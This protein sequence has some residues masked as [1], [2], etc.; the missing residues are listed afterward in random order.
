MVSIKITGL[1]NATEEVRE[2]T[3]RGVIAG[4]TALGIKGVQLATE[5][6]ASPYNGLPPAVATGNLANSYFSTITPGM[7]LSRL[8]I[9][10]GAPADTYVDPINSGATPHMPP[11]N[12]LLPWVKLK[13]GVDDAKAA[14]G[15]AWAIATNMKEK[16]MLGR[17]MVDRAQ[18]AIEPLGPGAIEHGIAEALRAA[19]LAGGNV[20]AQ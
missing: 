1:E 8:A 17:H 10:A 2:A 12:A 9:Q 11:V 18:A 20:A 5:A 15:I 7:F 19:G 4:L 14:L 6:T 16:G 3:H 13:F